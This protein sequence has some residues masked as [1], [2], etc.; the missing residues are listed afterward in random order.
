MLYY[1]EQGVDFTNEYGDIDE[2]F[3]NSM[4]SMFDQALKLILE[5]DLQDTFFSRCRAIVK[6]TSHI[7]WGF[8]DNL[9]AS[10]S[11]VYDLP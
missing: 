9:W 3:Y 2:P 1:V 7:G 11:D 4:E 6:K 8:H 5:T 10:F